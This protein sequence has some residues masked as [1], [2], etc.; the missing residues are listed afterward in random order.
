M[1]HSQ[2]LDVQAIRAREQRGLA[3]GLPLMQRAG[4]AAANFIQARFAQGS[5]VLSL[6]GP[7]N[8]G[9]DALVAS[10]LLAAAGYP[11]TVVMP[12]QPTANANDARQALADWL[13]AGHVVQS[14]MPP[15][16]PDVIIDGLF[17]IGLTRALEDPWQRWVDAVNALGLP[18][19]SLDVPSGIHADRGD[20]LG[21]AVQATW[22]LAF[23]AP[24][25]ASV[26]PGA[27][28]YFGECHVASLGI[29]T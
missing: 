12:Q 16:Q 29:P 3:L 26:A 20:P 25:L 2:P 6:V 23:I 24:S 9:G 19:L 4:C 22:T 21:R 13:A 18:V 15:G 10:R 27:K 14:Q 28:R 17:G 7:G 8:N 11:V 1:D 5:Q